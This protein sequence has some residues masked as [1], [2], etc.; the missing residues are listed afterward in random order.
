[1][2]IKP[3][4]RPVRVISRNVVKRPA[5]FSSFAADFTDATSNWGLAGRV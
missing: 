2:G 4:G 1:M 3:G 5:L